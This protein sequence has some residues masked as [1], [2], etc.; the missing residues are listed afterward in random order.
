MS[1][2]ENNEFTIAL[3]PGEDKLLFYKNNGE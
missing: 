1:G 2:K 3:G